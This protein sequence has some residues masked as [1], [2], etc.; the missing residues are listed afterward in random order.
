MAVRRQY[1]SGII[2]IVQLCYM[3]IGSM[4]LNECLTLSQKSVI[5]KFH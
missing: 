5:V 3:Y 1:R 4:S 2:I